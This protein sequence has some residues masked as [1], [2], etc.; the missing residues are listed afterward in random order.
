[1]VKERFIW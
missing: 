1:M